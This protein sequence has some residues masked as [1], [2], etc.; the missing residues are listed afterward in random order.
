MQE[1]AKQPKMTQ[2]ASPPRHADQ[3]PQVLKRGQSEPR[4]GTDVQL[5]KDTCGY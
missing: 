5:G 3:R 2:E 1:V 4:I